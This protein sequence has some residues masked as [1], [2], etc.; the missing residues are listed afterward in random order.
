M[1]EAN[2]D[3]KFQKGQQDADFFKKLH[4]VLC[5][6]CLCSNRV[7]SRCMLVVSDEHIYLFVPRQADQRAEG[8]ALSMCP[9]DNSSLPDVWKAVWV[10]FSISSFF[11]ICFFFFICFFFIS[12]FCF[13]FFRNCFFFFIVS[14]SVAE[15][16]GGQ[17]S[18][19]PPLEAPVMVAEK[20]NPFF[21]L[22]FCKPHM[23]KTQKQ[24]LSFLWSMR[25]VLCNSKHTCRQFR[26]RL[27]PA[28]SLPSPTAGSTCSGA[29]SAD[30]GE[31]LGPGAGQGTT[32]PR[33]SNAMA[34]SLGLVPPKETRTRTLGEQHTH[35]RDTPL[36][37]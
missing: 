37:A 15:S 16:S 25:T 13:V 24:I 22:A 20:R 2:S 30:L 32:A 19:L 34:R 1:Q 21:S 11:I 26:N 10:Y 31:L 36:W 9:V 6:P 17:D 4:K 23:Q 28:G 18:G 8:T 33:M 5:V 35:S 3:T 14:V 12:C 27:C 7:Q 29:P